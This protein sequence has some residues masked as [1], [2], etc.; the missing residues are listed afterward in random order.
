[1]AKSKL[2][3]LILGLL[4][5][6]NFVAQN[7]G[8]YARSLKAEFGWPAELFSFGYAALQLIIGIIGL[9]YGAIN[10]RISKRQMASFGLTLCGLGMAGL[11]LVRE[12]WQ[13]LVVLIIIACGS[14]L[15]GQVTIS[16]LALELSEGP[17]TPLIWVQMGLS[18]G[19]LLSPAI[20]AASGAIS[21][22]MTAMLMAVITLT[23]AVA[24]QGSFEGFKEKPAGGKSNWELIRDERFWLIAIGHG[25]ALGIVFGCFSQLPLYLGTRGIGLDDSGRLLLLTSLI[26]MGAQLALNWLAPRLNRAVLAAICMASYSLAILG[27]LSGEQLGLA[28]FVLIFGGATGLRSP[29]MMILRREAFGDNYSKAFGLSNLIVAGGSALGPALIGIAVSGGGFEAGFL[30]MIILSAIGALCFLRLAW[31][32][33]G[34]GGVNYGRGGI[35]LR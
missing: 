15:A 16:A 32:L 9:F 6:T 31:L 21:W 10:R 1:M 30:A 11:A 28:A 8:L 18:A 19:G 35:N 27:L 5:S 13:L 23:L 33:H 24:L 3:I 12:P 2:T 20:A 26:I 4:L 29:L 14:G 17:A 25:L 7:Y 22:Q 34:K